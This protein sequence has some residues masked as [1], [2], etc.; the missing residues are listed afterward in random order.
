[1]N[2]LP[3]SAIEAAISRRAHKR[4]F[5]APA[6]SA[7][8]RALTFICILRQR[9]RRK[10]TL[11]ANRT[12]SPPGAL[13]AVETLLADRESWNFNR[14]LAT[15]AAIGG[16]ENVKKL[17]GKPD[18][19]SA[20]PR[21]SVRRSNR[22]PCRCGCGLD[23]PNSV[24]TTAEDGLRDPRK[25]ALARCLLF[26]QYNGVWARQATLRVWPDRIT[27]TAGFATPPDSRSLPGMKI[28]R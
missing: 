5:D 25:N 3:Q 21:G 14:R 22:R 6:Q 13:H 2:Q 12:H 4:R 26:S 17:L 18:I 15:D 28:N 27:E 23:S 24:S 19:N 16:K 1:M 8:R 9:I 20:R 11:A 7:Q 10:K